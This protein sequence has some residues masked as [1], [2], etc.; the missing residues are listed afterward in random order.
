MSSKGAPSPGADRIET[1]AAVGRPAALAP[2]GAA[3]ALAAAVGAAAVLLPAHGPASLLRLP[4]G[5]SGKPITALAASQDGQLIAAGS[6]GS[7][8]AIYLFTA[9]GAEPAQDLAKGLHSFGIAALAFSPSGK[10]T[11]WL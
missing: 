9:G 5:A 11:W 4:P 1:A 7:R 10:C 6:R 2:A 8:P 3:G